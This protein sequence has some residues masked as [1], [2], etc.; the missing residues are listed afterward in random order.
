M[1]DILVK[2]NKE[3]KKWSVQK[4]NNPKQKGETLK[5]VPTPP[6]KD[7]KVWKQKI[8]APRSTR[9]PQKSNKMAWRPKKVQSSMST[10]P[11]MDVPS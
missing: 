3:N 5:V 1:V 8:E 4:K 2:K 11:G 7:K 6:K 9:T 10:P